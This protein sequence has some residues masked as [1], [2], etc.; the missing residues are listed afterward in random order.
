MW[1]GGRLGQSQGDLGRRAARDPAQPVEHLA[2]IQAARRAADAEGRDRLAPGV[3]DRGRDTG[4]LRVPLAVVDGIAPLPHLLER[5]AQCRGVRDGLVRQAGKALRD[6]CLRGLGRVGE[7]G[8]TDS[9]GMRR[10][11]R[12]D[13]VAVDDRAVALDMVDPDDLEAVVSP[14]SRLTRSRIGCAASRSMTSWTGRR[15]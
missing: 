11:T 10:D 5:T 1:M 4:G 13:R 6:E 14:V 7:Q 15:P 9:R 8:E 3:E 12:A 2:A